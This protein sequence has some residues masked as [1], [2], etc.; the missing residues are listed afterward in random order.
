MNL[1]REVADVVVARG[2]LTKAEITAIWGLTEA[3][4]NAVPQGT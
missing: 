2:R 1:A 3:E 4:Y